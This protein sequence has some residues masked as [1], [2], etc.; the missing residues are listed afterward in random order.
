MLVT[1]VSTARGREVEWGLIGVGTFPALM[2]L[3]ALLRG[4]VSDIGFY[5]AALPVTALALVLARVV[6]NRS[7]RMMTIERRGR[8]AKLAIEGT[9][10]DL[11]F[12]LRLHGAQQTYTGG[13]F[14]S[15]H[16][17]YLQAVGQDGTSVVF[18][19]RRSSNAEREAEWP[20]DGVD[21][22]LPL[23]EIHLDGWKSI[24]E[25]RA[26]IEKTNASFVTNTHEADLARA[27]D[28]P[29]FVPPRLHPP[30]DEGSSLAS[31][32]VDGRTYELFDF[33]QDRPLWL[34]ERDPARHAEALWSLDLRIDR[35]HRPLGAEVT[36]HERGLAV[37]VDATHWK[38]GTRQVFSWIVSRT[39][40][41]A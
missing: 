26:A 40:R 39:G 11:R 33:G 6:R 28:T 38:G 13:R 23:T 18:S 9:G 37:S 5:A 24:V 22:T 31:C 10:I 29:V 12:P 25:I 21:R 2:F 4:P 32:S 8:E 30:L 36:V 16:W 15:P 3:G 41:L 14:S 17:L 7:V 35:E 34:V 20:S 19:E 27:A 1:Q